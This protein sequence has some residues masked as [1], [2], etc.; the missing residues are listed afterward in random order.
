[1]ILLGCMNRRP[2]FKTG[3]E[4]QSLPSFDLLLLDSSTHL[5][6]NKIADR[7]P[8]VLLYFSSDCPYC[9]AQ[10]NDIVEHI[11]SFKDIN[12]YFLG[13]NSL[14]RIKDYAS[15]YYLNKLSNVTVG[16]DYTNKFK[17][18]FNVKSIPYLAIYNGNKKLKQVLLGKSDIE[19]LKA[20][21]LE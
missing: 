6:L 21:A 7:K 12:F 9:R 1:M 13:A 20:I 19:S 3:L 5:S 10:I 17:S 16:L 4:G 15:R 18:Y 11:R 2:V 8:I 14:S